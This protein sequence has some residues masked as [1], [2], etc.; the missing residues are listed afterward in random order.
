MKKILLYKRIYLI[1]LLPVSYLLIVLA[2]SNR[3]FAEEIYARHIY[4]WISQLISAVTG[5]FPFSIAEL[6]VITLPL[7]LL[8][9]LIR[10]MIGLILKKENRGVRLGKGLLNIL[11]AGSVV[12]FLFVLLCGM[13]YYRY[14]FSAYSNLIIQDSSVEELYALTKSLALEANELRAQTT[15]VDDSGVFKLSMSNTELAKEADQAFGLLAEEYPVLG[16]NYPPPKP[17]L[18][19]KLM[20]S[21]EITGIFF[22]FTME[23]NV[24]VDV[25]DYSIPSTMLH[26]LAH[27]RGFMREDEANFLAYLAGMKSEQPEI[28]YSSTMLALIIS[29]NA[30][31]DQNPEYYFEIRELFSDGI[32]R[33]IRA[34]SEYWMKYEDTAIS[35]I[36]NRV[37]DTY[38]KANAQTDGVRSY[39]RM[40]DLLLAKYRKEHSEAVGIN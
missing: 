6:I 2:K 16:G 39:G 28:R 13:N 11:C 12:L 35:T 17:I 9:V 27:L 20:S 5:L 14:N 31:Y 15:A 25:P 22:P 34:N 36:S 8:V 19:S 7:L 10:F 40:L 32:L 37:N 24:N 33:D 21:T 3:Y 23:A 30:L 1:G 38:L 18:L 26:E 29:G 4:R